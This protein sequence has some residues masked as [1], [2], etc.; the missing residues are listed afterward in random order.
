MSLFNSNDGVKI[1]KLE[2]SLADITPQKNLAVNID[3]F[4]R[5]AGEND[6][7][8]RIQRA[9]QYATDNNINVV[10]FNAQTYI[11]GTISLVSNIILRGKGIGS[12]N[13]GSTKITTIQLKNN[14]ND[15]LIVGQSQVNN[16]Q[17]QEM[18]LD[19]NKTNQTGISYGV[20]LTDSDVGEDP[21]WKLTNV[22]VRNFKNSG[23]YLGTNRRALKLFGCSASENDEYGIL[24]KASDSV[25]S[26]CGIFLNGK[27]GIKL[28]TASWV[29]V[30]TECAIFSNTGYGIYTYF[31]NFG[32]I[33]GNGI[34]RNSKGGIYLGQ[35]SDCTNVINNTIRSNSLSGDGLYS[36][37]YVANGSSSIN[38]S[39]NAFGL[40]GGY[41][42]VADF[43]IYLENKIIITGIGNTRSSNA[44]KS[45]VSNTPSRIMGNG[46]VFY[47][48]AIP[49][50]GLVYNAGD[51]VENTAPSTGGNTGWRCVSTGKSHGVCTGD[52][53]NGS[54]VITNVTN[55]TTWSVG[56][57]IIATTGIP[58]PATVTAVNTSTNTL[59]ISGNAW[60]TQTGVSFWD[61][62][63][64]STGI[65]GATKLSSQSDSV[66]ADVAT[67]KT[68]FNNLL[69][70]LR[71]AGL[72]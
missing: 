42:N 46:R 72:M 61:A 18:I 29:T 17:I 45:G 50:N 71:T 40:E 39:H 43:D 8:G 2:T 38:V 16:V 32:L 12:V 9:I 34:D 1:K 24:L 23:F 25:I 58:F 68:D 26:R 67:L 13:S 51:I 52:L 63:F 66:A 59:T 6:D 65:I 69:A 11:S 49:A 28:D 56:D 44:S 7:T 22:R 53:T 10:D 62:K 64:V 20:Y 57:N 48:T 4:L 5:I 21:T 36:H 19:G 60:A 31:S 41:T 3:K 15:N 37:V 55:I 70:K 47:G 35:A 54:S 27:E 14:A 30:I 33:Y